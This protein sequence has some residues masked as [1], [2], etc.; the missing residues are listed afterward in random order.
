M[1]TSELIGSDLFILKYLFWWK[2]RGEHALNVV[3]SFP[4]YICSSDRATSLF[5]FTE[6]L[7][8]LPRRNHSIRILIHTPTIYF[9]RDVLIYLYVLNIFLKYKFIFLFKYFLLFW[10]T[11]R[12]NWNEKKSY[13]ILI[14]S[15]DMYVICWNFM[16]FKI[17]YIVTEFFNL[18]KELR[19]ES[20][21]DIIRAESNKKY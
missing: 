8:R 5:G 6:V 14:C 17:K 13:C 7:F 2:D 21:F 19:V 3:H 10:K 4:T 20:I 1:H 11:M 16:S 15:Y 9:L 12:L 18:R